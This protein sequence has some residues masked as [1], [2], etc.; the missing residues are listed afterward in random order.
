M[1]K[2]QRVSSEDTREVAVRLPDGKVTEVH[3]YSEVLEGT[4][5]GAEYVRFRA[6]ALGGTVVS[7][8]RRTVV[9]VTEWTEL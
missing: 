4:M 2:R 9:S 1:G 8:M 7:R 5:S 3:R 6:R